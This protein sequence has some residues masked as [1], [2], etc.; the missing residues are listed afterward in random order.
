[1][2]TRWLMFTF[3]WCCRQ[4]LQ[5]WIL[6]RPKINKVFICH[7]FF[8]ITFNIKNCRLRDAFRPAA[9]GLSPKYT[10]YAFIIMVNLCYICHVKRTKINKKR[11]DLAHSK[12]I[13]YKKNIYKIEPTTFIWVEDVVLSKDIVG[14]KV[15]KF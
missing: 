15:T 2:E 6:E 4:T 10:I 13:F 1:M 8:K 14:Q 12:I 3:I 7:R 9:P 5:N 11:L